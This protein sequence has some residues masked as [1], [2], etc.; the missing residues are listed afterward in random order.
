MMKIRWSIIGLALLIINIILFVINF[1][2]IGSVVYK[3]IILI[4]LMVVIF[5]LNVFKLIKNKKRVLD[6]QYEVMLL[7]TNLITLFIFIRDKFD[8]M[9]PINDITTFGSN[10]LISTGLFIDYNIPFIVT[11]YSCILIYDILKFQKKKGKK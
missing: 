1:I 8:C 11:M 5:G 10:K 2:M 7:L 9:I 3:W 4:L 6:N